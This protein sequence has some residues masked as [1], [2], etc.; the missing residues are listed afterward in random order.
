M[1]PGPS[2]ARK[3]ELTPGW[4]RACGRPSAF[5]WPQHW[6]IAMVRGIISSVTRAGMR[7]RRT[8]TRPRPGRRSATPI[9][10][11]VGAQVGVVGRLVDQRLA[12][13]ARG[14]QALHLALA[15]QLDAVGARELVGI[16][17]VS[18]S[19]SKRATISRGASV[20]ARPSSA[21]DRPE[22]VAAVVLRQQHT[23]RVLARH[24]LAAGQPALASMPSISKFG[25]IKPPPSADADTRAAS[26]AAPD[27]RRFSNRV[28][29]SASA[30]R[31]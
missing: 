24:L 3:L 30:R 11:V 5:A 22:E 27:A 31:A 6:G 2:P 21:R 16:E 10:S 17:R 14:V 29:P 19:A 1:V 9:A 20:S 13:R 7:M 8:P 26:L 18:P 25:H 4:R 12:V 28:T 23:V 15:D